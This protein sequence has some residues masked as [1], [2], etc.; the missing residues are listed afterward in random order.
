MVAII[1]IILV[2]LIICIRS[3]KK[4]KLPLQKKQQFDL[5]LA[6]KL[7]L[8]KHKLEESARSGEKVFVDTKDY[9]DELS[10]LVALDVIFSDAN[11]DL[12]HKGKKIPTVKQV[13]EIVKDE[14]RRPS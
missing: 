9:Q 3:G 14:P 1:F 8:L 5:E 6:E 12:T 11:A 7:G 13:M 10:D 2:L 4:Q